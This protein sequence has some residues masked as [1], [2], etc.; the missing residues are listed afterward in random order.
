VLGLTVVLADGRVL[1]LGGKIVKNATGYQL[2]LLFVG[3]EGTLGVV[4]RVLL[5]LLPKP[6]ASATAQAIFA[7]LADASETVSQ[8]L[9]SGSLPVAVELMDNTTINLVEDH[10]RLGLPRQAEAI[11]VLEQDGAE[12]EGVLREMERMAEVC[13]RGG[14]SDVLVARTAA[15]REQVWAARR[16]VSPALGRAAPNKLGEDIV[17]P[18]AEIPEMVRRIRRI[19]EEHALLIPIFGHAGDGNLHPNLLF[20]RR[21]PGELERVE[22]AAAAIFEAAIELGG[23]LSGEHGIGTLKREFMAQALGADV[24]A[25]MADLKRLLDPQGILNP[26]KKFPTSDSTSGF[27]ATLPALEG[28]IPG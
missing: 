4:T 8:L 3:S 11:L 1:E 5:K 18:R 7:R 25:L 23:S 2:A 22:A 14:A 27:L 15:E 24:V 21:R 13:R 26:H 10:L 6:R 28:I 12:P 17:V 16:A 9:T 19:A 20:D